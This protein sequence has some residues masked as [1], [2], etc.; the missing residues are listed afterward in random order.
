MRSTLDSFAL[1][2]IERY[3]QGPG[4]LQY[5]NLRS[6]NGSALIR[7]LLVVTRR[8]QSVRG[9]ARRRQ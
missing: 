3:L 5:R 8:T 2:V 1:L 7:R 6:S 4:F 9:S